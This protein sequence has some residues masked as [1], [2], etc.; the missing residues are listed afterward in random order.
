MIQEKTTDDFELKVKLLSFFS[1]VLQLRKLRPKEQQS[2][3][4]FDVMYVPIVLL[5]ILIVDYLYIVDDEVTLY[6]H[7]TNKSKRRRDYQKLISKGQFRSHGSISL[8]Q[9]NKQNIIYMY[10]P[11]CKH[12][13]R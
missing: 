11:I 13:S 7:A 5:Y 9:T 2:I 4:W 12:S 3:S 8:I 10:N 1:P 6:H